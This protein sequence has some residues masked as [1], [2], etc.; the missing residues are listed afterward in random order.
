MQR[1]VVASSM[2]LYGEGCT[3]RRTVCVEAGG[4]PAR[5]AAARP[6]GSCTTTSGAALVPV[7]TPETQSAIAVARSMRSPS[8]IRSAV[9]DRSAAPT[10]S[11]RWRSDSSTSSAPRQALSNPYTGVLAIFA[12]RLLNDDR[13]SS[14]RTACS[15][16]ISS[17]STTSCRHAGS[18]SRRRRR[19]VCVQCRQRPVATVR[20]VADAAGRGPR[21]GR[22]RPRSP[23][24][25]GSAT[26]AIA[27][28]TS[29]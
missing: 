28:P 18:R 24:S 26:S 7:P 12:A 8:S 2:S 1:L 15:A 20:E 4:A 10:T 13:R 19:P 23:A 29:R 22:S 6:T 3:A 17:A 11:R 5:P 21:Q 27:S 9:P 14:S 25:T 16:A